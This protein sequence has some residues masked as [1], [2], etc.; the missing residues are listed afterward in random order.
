MSHRRLGDP[1]ETQ[2]L[3]LVHVDTARAAGARTSVGAWQPART[4]VEGGGDNAGP[5]KSVWGGRLTELPI[6]HSWPPVCRT[7][8]RKSEVSAISGG[9]QGENFRAWVLPAFSI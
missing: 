5:E 3:I 4:G 9:G 1:H 6:A 2:V 8:C 7:S